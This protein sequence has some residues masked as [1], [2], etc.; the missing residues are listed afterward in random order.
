MNLHEYFLEL[1]QIEEVASEL[2][3][4]FSEICAESYKTEMILLSKEEEKHREFLIE[5][6]NDKDL[7]AETSN[8][9]VNSLLYQTEYITNNCKKLDLNSEK[10][11]FKFALHIEKNSIDI[12]IN[13][14]SNFEKET[15]IYK[16]IE[17]LIK[18]E[19]K[20][21]IYILNRLYEL[22]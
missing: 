12:Y 7:M 6:S 19:R 1:A 15:N 13:L 3:R 20:H 16:S 4:K 18:E 14:L 17:G 2:Y 8:K 10:A 22:K 11:L 5:L 21:M 9:V